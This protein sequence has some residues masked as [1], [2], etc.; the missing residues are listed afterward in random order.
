MMPFRKGQSDQNNLKGVIQGYNCS[1]YGCPLPAS[2]GSHDSHRYCSH[3]FGKKPSDNDKITSAIRANLWIR[4]CVER[5]LNPELF[6]KGSRELSTFKIAFEGVIGIIKQ[7][8]RSDLLP[9]EV[10]NRHGVEL[11]ESVSDRA[12]AQRLSGVFNKAID[13]AAAEISEVDYQNAKAPHR[14]AVAEFASRIAA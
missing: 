2:M 13:K 10:T 6:Y 8:D 12:W 4:D 11:D 14:S 1:A 5:L 3:H 7:H 9:S